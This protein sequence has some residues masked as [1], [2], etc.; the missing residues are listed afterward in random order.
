VGGGRRKKRRPGF[1]P[2][3]ATL[4]SNLGC[5]AFA[6]F[7]SFSPPLAVPASSSLT[8]SKLQEHTGEDR[9]GWPLKPLA[10]CIAMEAMK[11]CALSSKHSLPALP[12]SAACLRVHL[13]CLLRLA[14]LGLAVLCAWSTPTSSLT[15]DPLHHWSRCTSTRYHQRFT[16]LLSRLPDEAPSSSPSW[17]SLSSACRCCC[18]RCWCLLTVAFV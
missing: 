8:M 14:R 9:I 7:F 10:R 11:F 16:R 2:I 5:I 6:P 18:C 15:T 3:A 13:R 1:R 17:S 12:P 4:V